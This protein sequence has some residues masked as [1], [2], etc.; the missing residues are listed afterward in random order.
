MD[1][2]IFLPIANNGWVISETAPQYMPTFALNRE[3]C[4]VAE[5]FGYEFALSMVKW[6]GF[7]G[8]TEH[9]D[10]AT[11]SLTLM[12][13]LAATTSS[14][15]LYASV[16]C[17]TLHPAIAARMAVTI[18][19]VSGGRFGINI[20]SGWNKFEYSQMGLWPGDEF[21]SSRYDY[22]TEW[23]QVMQLLW[24]T[25]HASFEGRY[26]TLDDCY[27]QPMPRTRIPVVCAGQSPRGMEFAGQVGD[28]NFMLGSLDE[29]A[30]NRRVLDEYATRFGREVGAY[31]LF[32][33][34]A[35]PTDDEAA[36]R[37]DL[38]IDGADL[39]ALDYQ[40]RLLTADAAGAMS[41]QVASHLLNRPSIVFP[42]DG[43]AATVQG[44]CFAIPHLVGSHERIARHLRALEERAGMDGVIMTFPDWVAD[45][46]DFGMHVL[47]RVGAVDA[48]AGSR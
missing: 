36:A 29:L 39:E 40:H 7:H 33:I 17:P 11:E 1:F 10:Y 45:A 46:T 18:D 42:D 38:Y 8:R 27:C 43:T 2:G 26:F 41:Q 5:Q 47:P 34:I 13:A 15:K 24:D 23:V 14:I 28:Y 20:V 31:A 22:S 48:A 19:D 44:A 30:R 16:A 6:R 4:E 37:A 3:I 35:A 12:S 32:G 25:G 21:Y 9:W